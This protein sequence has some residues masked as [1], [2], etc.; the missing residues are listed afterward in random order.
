MQGGLKK[1]LT[2]EEVQDIIN[3][4]VENCGYW[5]VDM[6]ISTST[7]ILSLREESD[8][9]ELH[10]IT[11]EDIQHGAMKVLCNRLAAGWVMAQIATREFDWIVADAIV[12]AA[13]FD[14]VRY[15]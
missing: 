8:P 15:G 13:I 4:A 11:A 9:V 10:R 1:L 14:E 12:Q 7:G 3:L 2:A 5:A 6:A